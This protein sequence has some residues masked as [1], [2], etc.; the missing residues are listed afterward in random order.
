MPLGSEA[1]FV[2]PLWSIAPFLLLLLSIAIVPLFSPKWWD[3]NT[4]KLLLSVVMSIPVLAVVAP[5]GSHYLQE[6]PVD[7]FSFLVLLGALFVISGGIYIKGAFAGTPLINT[8]FLAI[9][10]V[11]VGCVFMERTVILGTGRT[12]W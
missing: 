1:Q 5:A 11:S 7:Y 10:A 4:N 3:R 8:A 6:S 2:F 12:S 9:G